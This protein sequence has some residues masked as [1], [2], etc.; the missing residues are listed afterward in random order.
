MTILN[1]PPLGL[2][3]YLYRNTGTHASPTWSAIPKAINVKAGSSKTEATIPSRESRYQKYRGALIDF[4]INFTYRKKA[5]TDSVFSALKTAY[6]AGTP[7]EF[8]VADGSSA[9]SGTQGIRAYCE[10]MKL[11]DTQDLETAEEVAF[12]AKPTYYEESSAVVEPDW[13]TVP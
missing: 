5:G 12:V 6:F 10:L 13:Y 2:E 4:E 3:C 11:D 1:K 8:F 7:I 9:D